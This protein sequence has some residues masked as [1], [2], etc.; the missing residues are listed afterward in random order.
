TLLSTVM[1]AQEGSERR[2][3]ALLVEHGVVEERELFALVRRHVLEICYSIFS[4]RSGIFEVDARDG[5]EAER[6][7]LKV[8]PAALI[9]E[10]IRRK[11]GLAEA[12]DC[13]GGVKTRVRLREG[14][15]GILAVADLEADELEVTKVLAGEQTIGGIL[16]LGSLD[17]LRTYQLVYALQVLDLVILRGEGVRDPYDDDASQRWGRESSVDG[18]RILAKMAQV[19]EGDYFAILGLRS[20]VSRREIVQAY[21]RLREEL[22]PRELAPELIEE[23]G[24]ALFAIREVLEE[25]FAVLGDDGLREAYRDAIAE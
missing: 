4:W 23:H 18:R 22:D 24:D 3:G 5:V 7:R 19:K 15:A 6:I 16:G 2:L 25:A 9:V 8:H 17:E 12:M 14:V 11:V 10:G 13:L 20:D 1:A 21:R